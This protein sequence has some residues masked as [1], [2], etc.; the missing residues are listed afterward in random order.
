MADRLKMK[1]RQGIYLHV[2]VYQTSGSL[3]SLN[4][5]KKSQTMPPSYNYAMLGKVSLHGSM[6]YAKRI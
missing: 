4:K 1:H 3:N 2:T 6:R 5:Y